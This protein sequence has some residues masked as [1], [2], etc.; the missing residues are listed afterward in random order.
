M[1]VPDNRL[2]DRVVFTHQRDDDEENS[3]QEGRKE[4]TTLD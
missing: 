1:L 3:D 4:K 2:G